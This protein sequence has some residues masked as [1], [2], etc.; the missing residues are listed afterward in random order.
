[1][2]N[3]LKYFAE[4][5]FAKCTPPCKLSDMDRNFMLRLDGLRAAC[6]FPFVLSCA[7]RSKEY[8]LKKSRFGHSYHCKGRAV[9]ILCTNGLQRAKIV[10]YA[11]AFGLRGIGVSSRFIHLDDREYN[12]IWAYD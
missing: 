6:G 12:C 8:D 1:M 5:E 9:D 3:E 4:E 2:Q 11:P 10:Q 7:Y